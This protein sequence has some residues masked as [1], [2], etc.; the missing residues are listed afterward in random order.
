M[1]W[2]GSVWRCFGGAVCLIKSIIRRGAEHGP[3]LTPAAQR[4]ASWTSP[5]DGALPAAALATRSPLVA[6]LTPVWPCWSPG[7]LMI[8]FCAGLI[9]HPPLSAC[10]W[11]LT[12]PPFA[13]VSSHL[14]LFSF[15]VHKRTDRPKWGEQTFNSSNFLQEK[16][17]LCLIWAAPWALCLHL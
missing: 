10:S 3:S 4:W 9:P 14:L 11:E 5:L 6:E 8:S 12:A 7:G 16:S 15:P 13:P 2:L 17:A 1:L